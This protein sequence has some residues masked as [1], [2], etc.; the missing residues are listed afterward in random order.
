MGS[1]HAELTYGNR[2]CRGWV[3]VKPSLGAPL[4]LWEHCRELGVVP[5]DFPKQIPETRHTTGRV[6][7]A[8]S[9]ALGE[10]ASTG[11]AATS[12]TTPALSTSTPLPLTDKTFPSAAKEYFLQKYSDVLV[13]KK[14]LRTAPL[15]SMAG[16]PMRIYLR[17]GAQS[18]A[19][20][21]LRVIPLAFREAVKKELDSM[22]AQGVINPA[23][24]DPSP[25][26][27]PLVAV[28]KANHY[29]RLIEAE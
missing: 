18:F 29:H 3:D 14:A 11:S 7:G 16:P 9:S 24:D 22:M 5:R 27:H 23:G 17:E 10:D 19:I 1:F 8:R 12:T 6:C 20:H 13:T 25:W 26:C 15:R 28:A 2:R 21:T 4:L